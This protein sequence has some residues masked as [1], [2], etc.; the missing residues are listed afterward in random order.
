MDVLNRLSALAQ[1]VRLD[2]LLTLARH[3]KGLSAAQLADMTGALRTNASVHLTVLRNAGLVTS[4]R[5][6][7]AITYT[8]ERDVLRSLGA[9]LSDAAG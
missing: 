4:N 8:A 9:F 2:I 7:R 3:G 1:P 5:D 6:G